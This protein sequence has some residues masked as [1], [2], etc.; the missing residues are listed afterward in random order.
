MLG[1]IL[2]PIL[3]VVGFV[4]CLLYLAFLRLGH[5]LVVFGG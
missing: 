1:R 5:H 4:A 2:F 3:I